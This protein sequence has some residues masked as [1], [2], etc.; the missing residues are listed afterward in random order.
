MPYSA[1]VIS[2][3][4]TRDPKSIKENKWMTQVKKV[5]VIWMKTMY[6]HENTNPQPIP[7][8]LTHPNPQY[9]RA[10]ACEDRTVSTEKT[11]SF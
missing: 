5:C 7:S 4:F 8:S 11:G 1:D 9:F 6:E 2:K 10:A 3:V